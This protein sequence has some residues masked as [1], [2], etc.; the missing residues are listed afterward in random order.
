MELF[1]IFLS[2]FS[3]GYQWP[4]HNV[5]LDYTGQFTG[6]MSSTYDENFARSETSPWYAVQH[7]K[8]EKLTAL[9]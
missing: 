2:V 8:L 9:N 6:P 5:K 4:L 3:V 7:I 1:C